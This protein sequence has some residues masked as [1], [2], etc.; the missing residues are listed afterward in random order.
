V[1]SSRIVCWFS[2]GAA[3]AVA[4]RLV[5]AEHGHE[6]VSVVTTNPGSEHADND[7]FQAEC[8]RWFNHPITVLKS[9]KYA[10]T[11]EVWEKTRYL[12]GPT[13]ARCTGE[14]KKKLR[15]EFQR[16]D[17]VQVFGFTADQREIKR[18]ERFREQ[19]PEVDL[20]TPLIQRG[21]TKDDCLGLLAAAGIEVPEMYRLGYDNNNCV[22][23]VKG[24]AGYWNKIRVDFPEVFNRM[25][26]LEQNIGATVLRRNGQRLALI[27][28][29]PNAGRMSK[30]HDFECSVLCSGA[31][32][33]IEDQPASAG[34]N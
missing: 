13:G 9:A 18:A 28:L 20:R 7:R 26:A 23:C 5:I 24:G 12:V 19:N 21:L 15:F 31:L 1:G 22:G 3:S 14:L 34:R 30:P 32:Q 25:A 8:E 4:T 27:D 16:P 6:N 33:T 10:D 29:D 11:W 17:D 2:N